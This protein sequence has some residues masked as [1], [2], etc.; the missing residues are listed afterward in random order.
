MIII[1][2]SQGHSSIL[3]KELEQS[4]SNITSDMMI[5]NGELFGKSA[6]IVE[7]LDI[8]SWIVSVMILAMCPG[9]WVLA[10]CSRLLGRK[11]M[12]M[13]SMGL[14]FTSWFVI[15][16]ANDVYQIF[17]GR[18]FLGFVGGILVGLVPVYQ[19]E[20]CFPKL[21]ATLNVLHTTSFSLG[22]ELI[23]VFGNR[24][25]WRTLAM[26]AGFISIISL[27]LI[28]NLRESPI[29][30]LKKKKF[31]MAVQSWTF[32][33]GTQDF[34]ELKSMHN[35]EK[36]NALSKEKSI[37]NQKCNKFFKPS[38]L[39]PL[40]IILIFFTITQL[41][42]MGAVTHYCI[43]MITDIAGSDRAYV[44]TII[45]DSFRLLSSMTSSLFTKRYGPR[46]VALFSAFSTSFLLILLSLVVLFK[47][48]PWLA[49]TLL[50]AYEASVITGLL[51]LP[52]VFCGELFST[53]D[54]EIGIGISTS[55]NY[56][57]YFLVL[58]SNPDLV[59]ILQPWGAFLFYGFLTSIGSIVLYFILPDT[60]NKSLREI[61]LMFST[62]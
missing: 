29:W 36:L 17:I 47:W 8:R 57:L 18:I 19:G 15:V 16:F 45:L 2:M 34:D 6:I 26:F 37:D 27:F 14:F 4:K 1:G 42:G 60:K 38:F 49:L 10:I 61:E 46:T 58:K 55:Y 25:H 24:L 52:W 43:Q 20:C 59:L 62:E 39:K 22:V 50:F 35:S 56:V 28:Y 12:L 13:I 30:L 33:R 51:S 31:R 32:W 11:M 40:T 9:C 41:S 23:H 44:S 48:S 54:K 53:Y 7:S 3:M 5:E 21:R